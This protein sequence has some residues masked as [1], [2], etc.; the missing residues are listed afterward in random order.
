M[1]RC[2]DVH[3]FGFVQLNKSFFGKHLKE[4]VAIAHFQLPVN[5]KQENGV[6]S[7]ACT[8]LHV[9]ATPLSLVAFERRVNLD[10]GYEN[11]VF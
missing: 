7:F 2:I 4:C 1:S 10:A 11:S 5:R 6:N 9:Q 3:I 8:Y